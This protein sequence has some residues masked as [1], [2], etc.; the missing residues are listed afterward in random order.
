[1]RVD[2][3]G[4]GRRG[5]Q[6]GSWSV[7]FLSKCDLMWSSSKCNNDLMVIVLITH[8]N[9]TGLTCKGST[10]LAN[11]V[12]PSE[13][14]IQQR[15]LVARDCNPSYLGGWDQKN[16]G[17]RSAW[18]SSLWDLYLQNNQSKV[19]WNCGPSSRAP[20]LQVWSPEFKPLSHQKKKKGQ[21]PVSFLGDSLSW[22][23]SSEQQLSSDLELPR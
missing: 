8:K 6:K 23:L 13:T 20:A 19:D 1:V 2:A 9:H 12:L 11:D 15:V 21:T 3:E 18:A 14:R 5:H 22:G 16:H 7:L 17:L 10:E 4:A